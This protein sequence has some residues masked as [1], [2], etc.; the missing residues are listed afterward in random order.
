MLREEGLMRLL[1][2][3]L[4]PVAISL[5]A[6]APARAQV[7]KDEPF[8]RRFYFRGE[9][10]LSTLALHGKVHADGLPD[11]SVSARGISALAL[12]V[13]IGGVIGDYV[14][15]GAALNST[16]SGASVD[17]GRARESAMTALQVVG[18]F[19]AVFPAPRTVGVYVG[20]TAG[21]ALGL[22]GDA[23]GSGVG[24][25]AILGVEARGERWTTHGFGFR[26]AYAPSLSGD[27]GRRYVGSTPVDETVTSYAL[28]FGFGYSVGYR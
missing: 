16:M 14:V 17:R 2:L 5:L 21:Y 22:G 26:F 23:S 3:S 15:L 12:D 9:M 27:L 8:L 19:V 1:P 13:R 7:A 11:R 25:V 24:M 18:P 4:A 28:A 6:A 10:G 20:A